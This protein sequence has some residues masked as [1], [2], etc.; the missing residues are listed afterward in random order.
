MF[1][2]IELKQ[3]IIG[4]NSRTERYLKLTYIN[5]GYTPVLASVNAYTTN[6]TPSANSWITA[7]SLEPLED[8]SNSYRF[9]VSKGVSP[10]F[11]RMSFGKLN[12]L[13][14]GSLY[15]VD[16][17]DG[18][19]QRK[20]LIKNFSA[21]KVTLNNKVVESRLIDVRRWQ[22][23]DWLIT[24]DDA[25]NLDA[26]DLPDVLVAYPQYEV[27]FANDGSKQYT[28]VWG[29]G[30][31]GAPESGDIVKRIKAGKISMKDIAVVKPGRIL[32]KAELTELM[33]SRWWD[34]VLLIT[35]LVLL[36]IA[37]IAAA[38]FGYRRYQS[39]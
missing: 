30:S 20:P 5:T 37:V 34:K 11:L 17:I 15:T 21:Y 6:K 31:A 38:F 24:A 33:N 27:I 23:E 14:Q 32:D 26:D 22:S 29:N 7:G 4:I 16:N 19:L 39:K 13:L 8:G 10:S 3:N 36:V 1:N 12:T 28:V 9:S 2:G 25:S 35:G 18:K